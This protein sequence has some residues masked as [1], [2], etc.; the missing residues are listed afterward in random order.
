ML[1]ATR[2]LLRPGGRTAFFTIYTPRDVP[3]EHRRRARAAAPKYGYSRVDHTQ[4]MRSAGFIDVEEIDRTP[5]YLETLRGWHDLYAAHEDELV[6]LIS[7]QLFDDRQHDR[8]AALAAIEAGYQRRVLIV[9]ANPMS[10]QRTTRRVMAAR[11]GR[12]PSG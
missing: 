12:D 1:R 7:R 8:R 11:A 9:G 10:R 3:R 5:E 6:P 4:L 2:R